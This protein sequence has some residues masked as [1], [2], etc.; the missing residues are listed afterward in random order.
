MRGYPARLWRWCWLVVVAAPAAWAQVPPLPPQLPELP[1]GDSGAPQ[2]CVS[3]YGHTG[4]AARLYAQLLCRTV[5]APLELESLQAQLEEQ[6]QQAAIDFTGI[7]PEQVETAAVR[8]YSPMLCPERSTTIR[9]L[10]D[11]I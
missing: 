11:A 5:G 4:C 10:F 9:Q 6:Y 1:A 8:Y 7:T 3:R 2:V